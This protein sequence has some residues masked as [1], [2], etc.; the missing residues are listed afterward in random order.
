ML[1]LFRLGVILKGW[2]ITDEKTPREVTLFLPG[3]KHIISLKR[4]VIER[5]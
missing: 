3:I 5:R 2:R 4:K 1:D